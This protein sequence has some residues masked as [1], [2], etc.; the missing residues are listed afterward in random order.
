VNWCSIHCCHVQSLL[1]GVRSSLSEPRSCYFWSIFASPLAQCPR[2]RSVR[3]MVALALYTVICKGKGH[4]DTL[5]WSWN[6]H[7]HLSRVYGIFNHRN[8]LLHH[9]QSWIYSELYWFITTVGSFPVP[10][11]QPA[12][13]QSQWSYGQKNRG[14]SG[15]PII[16]RLHWRGV[17]LQNKPFWSR[18]KTLCFISSAT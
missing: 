13:F 5:K 12:K 14:F 10:G 4:N 17:H 3:L 11:P 1:L 18:S 2:Q 6:R 16:S 9:S 8:I 15:F 7:H